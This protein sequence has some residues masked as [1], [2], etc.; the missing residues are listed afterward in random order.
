MS[1]D[2]RVQ[3][4]QADVEQHKWTAVRDRLLRKPSM[5]I[6]EKTH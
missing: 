2:E 1:N 6:E 4:R 5:S 3:V